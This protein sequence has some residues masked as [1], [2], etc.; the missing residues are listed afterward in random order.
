MDN[1]EERTKRLRKHIERIGTAY[2]TAD[3]VGVS[4][5]T[6]YNW[7][8]EKSPIPAHAMDVLERDLY[9][10]EG[11]WRVRSALAQARDTSPEALHRVGLPMDYAVVVSSAVQATERKQTEREDA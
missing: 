2:K 10:D 5:Q 11:A 1:Q 7:L 9:Q 8:N 6:V 3:V 4:A